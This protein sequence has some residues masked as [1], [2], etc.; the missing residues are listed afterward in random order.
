MG[1]RLML[2]ALAIVT[3]VCLSTL[4]TDK[5]KAIPND[6]VVKPVP[7]DLRGSIVTLKQKLLEDGKDQFV[8]LLDDHTIR[9][10]IRCRL[11]TLET[12]AIINNCHYSTSNRTVV[13]RQRASSSNTS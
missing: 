13:I 2:V 10:A 1:S 3:A 11:R 4:A 9:K 5:Q 12:A 6:P 7:R 8:P